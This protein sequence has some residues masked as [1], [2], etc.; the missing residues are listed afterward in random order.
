MEVKICWRKF[1]LGSIEEQE[2]RRGWGKEYEGKGK[3]EEEGENEK[4]KMDA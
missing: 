2:G 1:W 3:I 4:M